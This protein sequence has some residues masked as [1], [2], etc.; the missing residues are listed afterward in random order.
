[1]RTFYSFS[2]A[3]LI[4]FFSCNTEVH[5]KE[6]ISFIKDPKDSLSIK[7]VVRM[8]SEALKKDRTL[9]IQLPEN[10]YS[11]SKEI[12]YPVLLLLENE[13]F[14]MTTGVVKH[15]SSVERM[16]ES[17]VVSLVDG[18]VTPKIYTNGSN[19]WRGNKT[20]GSGTEEAFT[21]H[22]KKELFP[23]LK[24]NFRAND[25]RIVMGSSYTSIYLLH[26]FTKEPELFDAHIALAAGDILSMGYEENGKSFI[27]LF[28]EDLHTKKRTKGYLYV[29]SAEGDGG[30]K[31]PEIKENLITLNKELR[32]YLSEDFR[33]VSKAYPNE[34]HYDVVL[35]G[36]IEA[37][38]MVF[39]IENWYVRYRELITKPGDALE[40]I[41]THF[42]K[43]SKKYGFKIV[44]RA[45]RWRSGNRLS[46]VGPYLLRQGRIDESLEVIE[47]W[48]EYRP[49]S[50]K[51]FAE[52]SKVYEKKEQ[53][54]DAI[55]ALNTAIKLSSELPEDKNRYQKRLSQL[56]LKEN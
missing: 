55:T 43:L 40:N 45:E 13:F 19:F 22:L 7:R 44:P 10:F 54:T 28:K 48:I 21:Q 31:A 4:L 2:I 32:P 17:I 47:R 39:P 24:E 50:H 35:P 51:A 49:Y 42:Q 15:L 1:M 46:W 27:D 14:Q 37:L 8:Y 3:L 23:Y 6:N 16:P 30:G 26:T 29:T 20:L 52:L 33:F 34:G 36:L 53:F 41:N 12:T 11:N 38:N 9:N 5:D 25:F 18:P 56:K